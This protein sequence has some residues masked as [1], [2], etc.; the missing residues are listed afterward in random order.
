MTLHGAEINGSLQRQSLQLTGL[1][2]LPLKPPGLP[3]IILAEERGTIP[4]HM[5]H[6]ESLNLQHDGA[7]SVLRRNGA[8]QRVSLKLGTAAVHLPDDVIERAGS[9]MKRF[10]RSKRSAPLATPLP[11]SGA[12]G[13]TGVAPETPRG[14]L[15]RSFDSVSGGLSAAQKPAL[16]PKLQVLPKEFVL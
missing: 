14:A 16:P 4:Q 11:G 15:R 13:I 12:A 5:I 9:L 2:M 6:L 10:K 3:G 8:L 1:N 7:L